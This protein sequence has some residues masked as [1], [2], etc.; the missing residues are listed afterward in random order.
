MKVATLG[1][2]L[3]E[4]VPPGRDDRHR[5]QGHELRGELEGHLP[6]VRAAVAGAAVRG[7]SG[8][9]H[10]DRRKVGLP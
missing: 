2:M 8:C 10:K 7:S 1:E 6:T 9:G 3:G 4:V 5:E